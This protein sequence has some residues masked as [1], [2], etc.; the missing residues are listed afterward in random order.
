MCIY[1]LEGNSSERNPHTIPLLT[2][3]TPHL[4]GE[5]GQPD[6]G[7]LSATLCPPASSKH[8]SLQSSGEEEEHMNTDLLCTVPG[9]L[10]T[11]L[12]AKR[13]I[14]NKR[15]KIEGNT[16]PL[17]IVPGAFSTTSKAKRRKIEGNFISGRQYHG[18][19]YSQ[20]QC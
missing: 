10:S 16:D 4:T 19:M 11:S 20:W 8:K 6:G 14:S 5:L 3:G 12:Q 17:C 2:S 15:R 13:R 9:A 7:P 18:H 1:I